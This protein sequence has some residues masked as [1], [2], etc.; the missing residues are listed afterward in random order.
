LR[1]WRAYYDAWLS[2]Q[3]LPLSGPDGQAAKGAQEKIQD[4]IKEREAE[5]QARLEEL[6]KSLRE[7]WPSVIRPVSRLSSSPDDFDPQAEPGS[8][9]A[10]G[11][12]GGTDPA[13]GPN[14]AEMTGDSS[15]MAFC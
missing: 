11:G 8:A 7:I 9:V 3:G 14:W 10:A 12:M 6:L 4:L 13:C 1:A 5:L 15:P 2:N